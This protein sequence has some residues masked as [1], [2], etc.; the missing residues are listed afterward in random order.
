M[1]TREPKVSRRGTWGAVGGVFR[2]FY[3]DPDFFAYT[4]LRA[5][6]W[7][8]AA[9]IYDDIVGMATALGQADPYIAE[10]VAEFKRET[11]H[12]RDW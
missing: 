9:T 11:A 10:H 7:A 2:R 1:V 12:L 6:L 8:L 3:I 5:F 4:E